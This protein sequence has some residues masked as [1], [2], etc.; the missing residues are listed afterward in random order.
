MPNHI[1]GPSSSKNSPSPDSARRNRTPYPDLDVKVIA[2]VHRHSPLLNQR[3]HHITRPG[4]ITCCPGV[5]VA[6]SS[7]PVILADS[8]AVFHHR[9]ISVQNEL[10]RL[11]L[12]RL[13]RAIGLQFTRGVEAI[14]SGRR[15]KLPVM[16]QS[17]SAISHQKH[18]MYQRTRQQTACAGALEIARG[19]DLLNASIIENRHTSDIDNASP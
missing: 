18:S 13:D 15:A 1:S 8:P 3:H 17:F 10:P 9:S 14:C 11:I 16:P 2:N 6:G 5:S 7:S 4:T 19:I 12:H